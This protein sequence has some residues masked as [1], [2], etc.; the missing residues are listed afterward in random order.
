MSS[1]E[2]VRFTLQPDVAHL[3]TLF[4]EL[5]NYVKSM[6]QTSTVILSLTVLFGVVTTSD[7]LV[8]VILYL[9]GYLLCKKNN[10]DNVTW[11]K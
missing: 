1:C 6:K 10:E 8:T 2:E 9:A 3:R 5:S 7:R 11:G 4:H